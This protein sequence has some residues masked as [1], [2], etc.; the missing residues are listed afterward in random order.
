MTQSN[1]FFSRSWAAVLTLSMAAIGSALLG[2]CA[3]EDYYCDNTGCYYCDGV[4]CRTAN[5][6]TRAPCLGDYQCA[7]GQVCTGAGCAIA[8]TT[9]GVNT[10]CLNGTVCRADAS[11]ALLCQAPAE[12]PVSRVPGSCTTNAGCAT[13]AVCLNGLCRTSTTPVCNTDAECTGGNVC[14]EHVCTAR[15]NTCQFSN[16]C[17][18]GRVCVNSECR[19][20]CAAVS[21]P[22]GQMCSTDG[23]CVA[24]PST[25]CTTDV[26][27][28]AGQHCLN[29]SCFQAC[30][31]STTNPCGSAELYCSDDGV[32][33]PDTRPRP[34]CTSDAGCAAGSSCVNGVCR[35]PCATDLI[36]QMHDVTYRNCSH[37]PNQPTITQTYCLTDNETSPV[38]VRQADCT[39]GRSC[40]DGQCR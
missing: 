38:C 10:L 20:A 6:P 16:Q 17:G 31:P 2:G 22:T 33:V 37:I 11:G 19:L 30:V 9:A 29:G 26:Q 28:G 21:C 32:C 8:C 15:T 7:A 40:L 35:L 3:R 5:P 39:A 12:T 23:Y 24:A 36:C 27:C 1:S 14:L 34:F 13:G 4:G 25:T 18:A